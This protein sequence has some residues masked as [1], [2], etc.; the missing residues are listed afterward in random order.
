MLPISD[1]RA[2]HFMATQKGG[3]GVL[4][5]KRFGE[6]SEVS[7]DRPVEKENMKWRTTMNEDGKRITHPETWMNISRSRG[8]SERDSVIKYFSARLQ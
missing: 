7:T 8:S 6:P 1:N 2:G 4:K 3:N 5:P